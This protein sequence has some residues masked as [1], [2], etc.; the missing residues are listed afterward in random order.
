MEGEEQEGEG[1]GRRDGPA[2]WAPAAYPDS[3]MSPLG[4]P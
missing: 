1:G 3:A 2:L 4:Q